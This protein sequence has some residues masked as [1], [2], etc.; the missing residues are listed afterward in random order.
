MRVARRRAVGNHR[1]RLARG[2]ARPVE[3]LDVEDRRQPAE[4][5]RADAERVDLV[6][7]LDS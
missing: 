7:D 4:P 1:H 6:E 3:D 2:V 5:L